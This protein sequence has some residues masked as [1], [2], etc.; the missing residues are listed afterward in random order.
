MGD[1]DG[2]EQAPRSALL[3]KKMAPKAKV[4]QFTAAHKAAIDASKAR[5]PRQKS[6]DDLDR[7]RM[8]CDPVEA[9]LARL[10]LEIHNQMLKV[11]SVELPGNVSF[12]EPEGGLPE[13]FDGRVEDGIP[14]TSPHCENKTYFIIEI[15]GGEG[16]PILQFAVCHVNLYIVGFRVLPPGVDPN[17][18]SWYSFGKVDIMKSDCFPDVKKS[19][20][21]EGYKTITKVKMYP[22][23]FRKIYI[24]FCQYSV[25][26]VTTADGEIYKDTFFVM[27]AEGSRFA[28]FQRLTFNGLSFFVQITKLMGDLIR[29]WKNVSK[30]ILY[31]WL[32]ELEHEKPWAQISRADALLAVQAFDHYSQFMEFRDSSGNI[33][34]GLLAGQSVFMLLHQSDAV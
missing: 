16:Q 20:Y 2:D 33:Q 9:D 12:V 32:A 19:G 7:I 30:A 11:S 6:Y 21:D 31:L 8:T 3:P 34:L 29:D 15:D 14:V 24:H 28:F 25:H 1:G 22:G 27:I 17:T 10:Y 13:G 5:R 26:P 23:V 18:V 4:D